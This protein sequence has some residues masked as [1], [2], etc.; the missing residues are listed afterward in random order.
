MGLWKF[1]T[2]PVPTLIKEN[3][4][5]KRQEEASKKYHITP[6]GP[7]LCTAS[8]RECKYH[9]HFQDVN[10]AMMYYDKWQSDK[11]KYPLLQDEEI[12]SPDNDYTCNLD[13]LK[14][15]SWI[16]D[17]DN[18]T[19]DSFAVLVTN[20]MEKHVKA[21]LTDV[22][23]DAFQQTHDWRRRNE[24]GRDFYREGLVKE[25]ERDP[26]FMANQEMLVNMQNYYKMTAPLSVSPSAELLN[27]QGDV[28]AIF[29]YI[30]DK[31]PSALDLV[32]A[33]NYIVEDYSL[34][35]NTRVR[36]FKHKKRKET[37]E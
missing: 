18:C 25:K 15:K 14:D 31:D 13:R 32:Q 26:L 8:I 30:E 7:K 17:I 33:L 36:V 28:V 37:E 10:M 22:L 34:D 6:D 21:K 23:I 5:K 3:K 24:G 27:H 4:E 1:L 2:T 19:P 11:M 29:K 35:E 12:L 20:D 16:S 9:K